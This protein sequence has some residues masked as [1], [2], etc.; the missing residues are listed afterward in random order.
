MSHQDIETISFGSLVDRDPKALIKVHKQFYWA[1][2][3]VKKGS[4]S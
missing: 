3:L 1:E 2:D 4:R